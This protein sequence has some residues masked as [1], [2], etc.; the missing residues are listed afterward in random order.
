MDFYRDTSSF[1]EDSALTVKIRLKLCC[2]SLIEL[3]V[4]YK[5]EGAYK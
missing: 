4:V 5:D 2:L 1:L 3:D